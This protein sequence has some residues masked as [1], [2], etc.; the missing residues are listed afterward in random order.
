MK[1]YYDESP[2]GAGK[3]ER[4]IKGITR[5]KCKAVFVTE[6]KESFW[7]L[8]NRIATISAAMGTRPCVRHI[9]GDMDN[10]GG[11]VS[12]AVEEL[13]HS[14][15]S[16][17]HVIVI[18]T[19]SAF[20]GSD[21]SA[22][23]GWRIVIDEVPA[24][25]DFQ[26]KTTHLDA[27][28]FCRH[29]TLQHISG[30]WHAVAATDKGLALSAADVRAD[31]S[32]RHLSVFHKRVLEASRPDANRY[33]LCNLPKWSAMEE[34]N[35]QWCW[36]STFSL[37]ELSAF[38][39]VELLGNRFRSDIGSLL[40]QFFDGEDVDWEE[41]PPLT[42]SRSFAQRRVHISYFSDRPSAKSLFGKDFGQAALTGIGAYLV[43][44]LPKGNS[45]WS[46]NDTG[47]FGE[48]TPRQMLGLPSADYVSPKQAGTNRFTDLSHAAIIYAAKPSPNLCSL[49][50]A[51]GIDPDNWTRSIEHETILQ[52]VTRTS[53]RDPGNATSVHLYVFDR[54]QAEYLKEYFYGLPHVSAYV[55]RVPLTLA[56]PD[57][58]KGGR[59]PKVRTPQEHDVWKAEKR[60]KDAERKRKERADGPVAK[61]KANE[62]YDYAAMLSRSA[63]ILS[64]AP[65]R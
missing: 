6:R 7:E 46:A 58:S 65:S 53:V 49:L 59:P 40:T 48:P 12:K 11:S 62:V 9:H 5:S 15:V 14:Y 31:D 52:F 26:E 43:N 60:K 37:R 30:D 28:Y 47:V 54:E 45:I 32:H 17:D 42:N 13:P 36:A 22:F 10:L 19:H 24:F 50:K 27:A 1:V 29:Y 8:H 16:V 2:A 34:R 57:K 56:I 44:V 25:L 3:T 55:T 20:L 33:V 18:I 41:L 35:V 4:A 23:A 64:Y 38:E 21:F 61:A 63:S 39:R 51:L